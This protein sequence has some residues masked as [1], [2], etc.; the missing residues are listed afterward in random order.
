MHQHQ[1]KV[2]QGSIDAN[3]ADY[4]MARVLIDKIFPASLGGISEKVQILVHEVECLYENKLADGEENPAVKPGELISR[5]GVS[6]SSVSRWLRPAIEAGLID[7]IKETANGRIQVV[8]PGSAKFQ[9]SGVLPTVEQVAEA[10][11]QLA[12]GFRAVHPLT[13]EELALEEEA[14]TKAQKIAGVNR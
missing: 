5:V 14:T 4:F 1:R 12:R 10:F 7:V 13:G 8:K 11:P 2:S 6:A 9:V 3:L